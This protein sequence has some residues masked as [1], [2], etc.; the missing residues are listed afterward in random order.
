MVARRRANLDIELVLHA[1]LGVEMCA[2]EVIVIDN[3]LDML[4]ID[5][6]SVDVPSLN[7]QD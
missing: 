3:N 6:P 5:M 4:Q 7:Y 1:T 2:D